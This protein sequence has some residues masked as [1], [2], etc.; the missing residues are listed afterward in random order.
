MRRGSEQGAAILE[1]ALVLPVLFVLFF[2]SLE[3]VRALEA[4]NAIAIFSREAAHS[5]YSNCL[6]L[7]TKDVFGNDATYIADC[8]QAEGQSLYDI[9]NSGANPVMPQMTMVISVFEYSG[10]SVVKRAQIGFPAGT[11][12]RYDENT[13]NGPGADSALYSNLG[14]VV[15]AETNFAFRP[16]VY[17]PLTLGLYEVTIY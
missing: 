4:K 1:L 3:L 2:A 7:D 5:V 8:V 6:E 16:I 10:G 11:P 14:K 15:I 13:G 9:A 12:S 17:A